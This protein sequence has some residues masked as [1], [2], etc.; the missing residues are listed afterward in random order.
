[1]VECKVV[2]AS[3]LKEKRGKGEPGEQAW[4]SMPVVP[5]FWMLRQED[6]EFN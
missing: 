3:L 4:Q 5:A 1:M 2:H 6:S